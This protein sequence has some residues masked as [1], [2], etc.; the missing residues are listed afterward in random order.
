MVQGLPE[1]YYQN[2]ERHINAVTRE[3]LLRVARK[4]LDPEHLAVIVVG[5]RSKIEAPLGATK[6][7]PLVHLDLEGNPVP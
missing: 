5:D 6:I 7:A 4:Y 2:F 3:D 1:D